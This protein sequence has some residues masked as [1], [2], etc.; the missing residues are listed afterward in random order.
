[1]YIRNEDNMLTI[2]IDRGKSENI[3]YCSEIKDWYMRIKRFAVKDKM[4]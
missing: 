4:L 1:M 3:S 2:K